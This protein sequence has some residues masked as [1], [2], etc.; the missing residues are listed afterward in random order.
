M[1][2]RKHNCLNCRHIVATTDDDTKLCGCWIKG[3]HLYSQPTPVVFLG[4]HI[5]D[6][7][8]NNDGVS[9]VGYKFSD[10]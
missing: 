4:M 8:V 7:Y 1:E 6:C 9:V 2:T 10:E 3:R 5:C